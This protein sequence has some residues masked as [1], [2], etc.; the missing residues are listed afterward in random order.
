MYQKIKLIFF[1]KKPQWLLLTGN[2]ST[3]RHWTQNGFHTELLKKTI[4]ISEIPAELPTLL[5]LI[6]ISA[7][8]KK[9]TKCMDPKWSPVL[10]L[11]LV[12]VA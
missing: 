1:P 9:K 11:A 12:L 2:S 6:D 7:N 5:N 3:L 10:E 8:R 4:E